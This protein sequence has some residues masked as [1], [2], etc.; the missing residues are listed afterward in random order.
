MKFGANVARRVIAHG[1]EWIPILRPHILDHITEFKKT[2]RKPGTDEPIPVTLFGG[3]LDDAYA[4]AGV[5]R[6][7]F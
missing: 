7:L 4:A 5:G 2:A 1:D 6:V 3:E